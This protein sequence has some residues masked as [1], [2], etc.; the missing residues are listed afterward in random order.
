[1]CGEPALAWLH[2]QSCPP[3]G[4]RR[5]SAS[6]RESWRSPGQARA[7]S[8][9]GVCGLGANE[10]K[11][12]EPQPCRVCVPRT[13]Y[14]TPP[15]TPHLHT[16]PPLCTHLEGNPRAITLLQAPASHTASGM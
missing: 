9:K 13:F 7:G 10:H 8:A 2:P 5:P 3:S 1:M 11:P 14:G 12:G 16:L 4:A 15:L 6:Q